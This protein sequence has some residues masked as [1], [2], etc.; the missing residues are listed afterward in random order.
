MKERAN[1]PSLRAPCWSVEGWN[2]GSRIPVGGVQG[3]TPSHCQT[4]LPRDSC[5]AAVAAVL[6]RVAHGLRAEC[7]LDGTCPKDERSHAVRRSGMSAP[8][9]GQKLLSAKETP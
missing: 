9:E 4:R 6:Y 7:A 3:R 8:Q 1:N 5:K 2:I